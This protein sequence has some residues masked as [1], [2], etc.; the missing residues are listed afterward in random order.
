[1]DNEYEIEYARLFKEFGWE[2]NPF[3]QALFR[4]AYEQG[5]AYGWS[6][7]KCHM[8]DMDESHKTFQR[9]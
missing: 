7:V 2:D 1:M 8:Y 3:T 4:V 9:R 5:H 6:E